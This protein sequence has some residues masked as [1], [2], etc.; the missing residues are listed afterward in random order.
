MARKS[1][2]VI[3][4][5]AGVVGCMVARFLSRYKLNILHI[6]K[7]ADVC[8]GATAANTAIVHAGYD[9]V[10][11][12][13]KAV[14]NVEGNRMWDTLAGD[15][16]IAF[17]RR[18]DYVVAIGKEEL[19]ALD[20]LWDRGV[21]NGVPGMIM[22]SGAE[23]R[24]REPNINQ[25]VSGALWAS[26][27]G[28]CDPFAVTVA[29]A[30]NAVMNGATLMLN[31][32]FEDFV[33]EGS[34]IVGVK[35]NRGEFR[36]RWVVNSAGLYSDEV[37][38]KAGVRPEFKITP[39][40]GEYYVFDQAEITINNVL[41]PVPSKVSKGI[42]VTTTVHGNTII[43]P[44]AEEIEDK[45]DRSVTHAGLDE[46]WAG[47]QKLVPKLN[48][49]HAIAVFAG[50]RPGGNGPCETPGVDYG[51]DY[52]IEIPDKVQGLVNLGGIESPGLTSAPAIAQRVVDLLK[53][54]GEELDE[55]PDWDPIRPARP[56]F[57]DLMPVE[58]KILIQNDPRYGRI[59]CRCEYV[60]E[61]EIVAE[62]HAPI[63]A[64][65]YDAIK[66]R[67][68]LGTGRCQG[69]FDTP[70]VVEILARELG[71]S[72]LDVTKKGA[73]STMLARP[74]KDVEG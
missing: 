43:G 9:P 72:L 30:E 46:V 4:I 32:A 16:A 42:L 60:T 15:L 10:P 20:E 61:G 71:V 34:R 56:R 52:I 68:W 64:T 23:V 17:E 70:R 18:G 11:G 38:H 13:L 35:T 31:T 8:M 55:K 45:E 1:Y 41:F 40:R 14:M 66:R 63:P 51:K 6:E 27:G 44:N 65:T 48:L 74:T 54:A 69:G 73:G 25:D 12:S 49:R 21:K 50:L 57:R 62:I 19:P 24:R 5:G 47:A 29:A 53:D 22:L 39:R 59:V 3:I 37:M 33:M 7:D 36:S 26:T 28:I 58:Q 2:D 67:T